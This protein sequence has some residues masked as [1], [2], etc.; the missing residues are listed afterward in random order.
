MNTVKEMLN[1]ENFNDAYFEALRKYTK[2]G[3][4]YG[5]FIKISFTPDGARMF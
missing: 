3:E 5:I 1:N 4:E 2:N